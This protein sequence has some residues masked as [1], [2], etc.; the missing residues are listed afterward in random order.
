ME[1]ITLS[2][3][4]EALLQMMEGTREHLFITGRAGA[5]KSVLLRHF[6]EYTRKRVVITAPTGIAALNV[7]GQTL[8][9]LFKLPPQL[10]R[11]GTLAPNSRL[12]TLL[13]RIDTLVIDEISM[14]RADLLDA[15]DERL[16]QACKNDLPFGGVQVIMF[17][18]VY[19]LPPV[20]EEDLMHY[21]EAVH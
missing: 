19:Q 12:S 3:E 20:V 1:N 11:K 10:Q 2:A 16:R 8:H 21:F 18:D 13:K 15:V 9:S 5:G 4:Q 7:Q 6:R 14:V 17:G